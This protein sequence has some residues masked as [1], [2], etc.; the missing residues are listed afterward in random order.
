[1][2]IKIG[3]IIL[4]QNNAP[5]VSFNYEYYRTDNNVIIGGKRNI[6]VTGV[7]IVGDDGSLTASNV[8]KELKRIR[9]ANNY[10]GK[11]KQCVDVEIPNIYTG[12]ARIVNISI[13]QGS[14]PTWVNQGSFS[15]SL[16]A[17]IDKIPPNNYGIT[18]EDHVK[19]LSF[20]EKIDL[21]EDS[22]GFV[23]TQD[24]NLSKAFV[25]FSCKVS[26]EI[27]PICQPVNNNTVLKNVIRKFIR[28]RPTHELLAQYIYWTPYIQD[29][30][31]EVTSTNSASFNTSSILLH[32]SHVAAT[33]FV[34]IDFKHTKSYDS[35]EETK[36]IS[37]NIKGLVSVP[38]TDIISISSL[39]ASPKIT[40]AESTLSYIIANFNS[41]TDWDGIDYTLFRY[42][43]P[44]QFSN[45]PNCNIAASQQ[46]SSSC[47]KPTTSTIGRART[48]GSI[49][50]SFEW[51]NLDCNRNNPSSTTIEYSVDDQRGQPS[52][53]EHTIPTIGILIQDLNCYSARRITFTSTVSFPENNCLTQPN[54][55]ASKPNQEI[56][57][58]NYIINYLNS[59]FLNP[60][61]YLLISSKYSRTNKANTMTKGYISVCETPPLT[62]I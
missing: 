12:I 5:K 52:M 2:S 4:Q 6:T 34:G 30:S 42:N 24:N 61:D 15:I 36:V 46:S 41:V 26:A 32:P 19:S 60:N 62:E 28:N 9:N 14:D 1:M 7:V 53:R 50:F 49:D 35:K 16:E 57:L 43:C 13:E 25:N 17:K 56:A 55:C 31:Y 20:S 58:N 51:S 22:H 8:M 54:P 45:D 38:W 21:G 3:N 37:G 39:N 10:N 18:A 33:S 27:D 23:Y 44:N 47:L 11:T 40:N 59:R 48:E 29:R